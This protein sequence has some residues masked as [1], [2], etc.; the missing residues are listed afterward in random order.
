MLPVATLATL[1]EWLEKNAEEVKQVARAAYN[2]IPDKSLGSTSVKRWFIYRR[3]NGEVPSFP[4]EIEGNIIN[5][6]DICDWIYCGSI[7]FP[8]EKGIDA[9]IQIF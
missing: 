1:Q 8:F 7:T 3:V 5:M 6:M 4:L 2:R 9:D